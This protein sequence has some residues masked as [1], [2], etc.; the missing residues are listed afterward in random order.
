MAKGMQNLVFHS[1]LG[2]NM[3]MGMMMPALS[4]GFGMSL[5]R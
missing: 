1:P 4:G 2:M 3:M 5:M